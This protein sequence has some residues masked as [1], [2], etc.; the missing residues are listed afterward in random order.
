MWM[1]GTI[2]AVLLVI[3][4]LVLSMPI[5]QKRH[6]MEPFIS[7]KGALQ[8]RNDVIYHIRPTGDALFQ[9]VTCSSLTRE[10][11]AD[12]LME[13]APFWW[14]Y[15]EVPTIAA[16]EAGVVQRLRKLADGDRIPGPVYVLMAWNWDRRTIETYMYL[17]TITPDGV[18]SPNMD[19]LG[20]AHR[21]FRRILVGPNY[22]DGQALRH[23]GHECAVHTPGAYKTESGRKKKWAWSIR[24]IDVTM[25]PVGCRTETGEACVAPPPPKTIWQKIASA[26]RKKKRKHP[27]PAKVT[28]FTIYRVNTAH[29][30]IAPYISPAGMLHMNIIPSN[31][32]M[33]L[34]CRY[35]L[36]S[37]NRKY[38]L[39]L[40]QLG[41]SLYANSGN[42]NLDGLCDQ[43]IKPR[44]ARLL[45]QKRFSRPTYNTH[46][47]LEDGNIAVYGDIATPGVDQDI[48]SDG[49][50]P[51][52]LQ[53]LLLWEVKAVQD[54]AKPPYAIVLQNNGAWQVV[55][56][57]NAVVTSS[58]MDVLSNEMEAAVSAYEDSGYDAKAALR[59]RLE[60]LLK[61][62][63]VHQLLK[64]ED[65]DIYKRPVYDEPPTESNKRGVVYTA[66]PRDV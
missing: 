32:I 22:A 25:M 4:L 19:F 28:Y 30:R 14:E 31:Q 8:G 27:Q 1:G 7:K 35:M 38:F 43:N 58:D 59:R 20:R 53:Q 41:L 15:F 34:G 64:E 47:M 48:P 17:P 10:V 39:K 26:F 45:W 36:V 66:D 2:L 63:R 44:Y 16:A 40:E 56:R 51:Q 13:R 54:T 42:E 60:L 33:Y 3:A 50:P 37:D 23:L 55:D 61:F 62:L 52:D 49:S 46:L 5:T 21:W 57:E 65:P 18:V 29:P 12:V 11:D 9:Y 6:V 24:E